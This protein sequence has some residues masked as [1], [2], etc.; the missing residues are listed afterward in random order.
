MKHGYVDHPSDLCFINISGLQLQ[1][2]SNY[3]CMSTTV[4][5]FSFFSI[6]I[7]NCLNSLT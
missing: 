3:K 5:S 6:Q 2:V 7:T 1:A 4:S